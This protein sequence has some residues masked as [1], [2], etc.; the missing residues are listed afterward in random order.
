MGVVIGIFLGGIILV[1]VIIYVVRNYCYKLWLV[2]LLRFG[3]IIVIISDGMLLFVYYLE[4]F[5]F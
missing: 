2:Y 5:D 4:L 1:L 3:R